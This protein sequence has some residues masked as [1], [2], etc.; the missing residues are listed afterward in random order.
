VE[1]S[2]GRVMIGLI[3]VVALLV[4]VAVA[5]ANTIESPI[6]K[7][8]S[9]S[10]D[11][12]SVGLETVYAYSY[13]ESTILIAVVNP[14]VLFSYRNIHVVPNKNTSISDISDI[15]RKVS[16]FSPSV[17]TLY[18]RLNTIRGRLVANGL[19]EL[20][21]RVEGLVYVA[22]LSGKPI[23]RIARA[24]GEVF[25]DLN[26]TVVVLDER[27]LGLR[28]LYVDS[29]VIELFRETSDFNS[30]YWRTLNKTFYSLVEDLVNSGCHCF[31]GAYG[32]AYSSID[33]FGYPL[34]LS[35]YISGNYEKCREIIE[36]HVVELADFIRNYIP[37][38]IPLYILISELPSGCKFELLG[39]VG[40]ET[41]QVPSGEHGD[42][43]SETQRGHS[44][45]Y[46][47]TA[48]F[49]LMLG[50]VAYSMIKRLRR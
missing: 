20:D 28:R 7:D 19:S 31:T 15:I 49:I 12:V 5:G 17:V 30:D 48:A 35:I 13:G 43:G 4:A 3:V 46:M 22:N 1:D 11:A 47:A 9:T 33:G 25:G 23:D 32:I 29:G 45:F 6:N 8:V 27:I 26:V 18:R 38:E 21:I 2:I 16:E 14:N 36:K 10:V 24:I 37:E 40:N 44:L 39:R 50:V 34:L 41:I 42:P